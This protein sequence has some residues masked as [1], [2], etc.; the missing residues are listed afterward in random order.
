MKHLSPRL[1]FLPFSLALMMPMPLL[2]QQVTPP[3]P[4][5]MPEPVRDPDGRVI[6][7]DMKKPAEAADKPE[8]VEST[9]KAARAERK[10]AARQGEKRAQAA[11]PGKKA[12]T[13]STPRKTAKAKSKR[14]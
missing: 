14:R 2:A 10:A 13:A 9:K 6:P 3:T 11:K 1:A 12:A 4:H 7:H 5:I 8:K